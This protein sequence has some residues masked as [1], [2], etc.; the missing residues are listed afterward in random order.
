MA[1]RAEQ[2][3]VG[4]ELELRCGRVHRAA[5]RAREEREVEHEV[6]EDERRV[7]RRDPHDVLQVRH[8]AR[9]APTDVREPQRPEEDPPE[10]GV[11]AELRRGLVVL[12][13][14]L[15]DAGRGRRRGGWG[16][17]AGGC[18]GNRGRNVVVGVR[19]DHCRSLA[20]GVLRDLLLLAAE[21]GGRGG[22]E[23]GAC[24]QAEQ[25]DGEVT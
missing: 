3:G 4:M 13:P 10:H 23:Q 14:H 21:V 9:H 11:R 20:G 7:V 25:V 1:R 5:E 16:R 24:G 22:K 6:A 18:R 12:A 17:A 19:V 8:P 2:A 15:D